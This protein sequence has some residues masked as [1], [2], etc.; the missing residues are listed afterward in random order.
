MAGPLRLISLRGLGLLVAVAV[1]LLA[2]DS[3]SVVLTRMSE[4]DDV[5][6]AGYKAAEVAKT[7]PTVR[8]VALNALATAR[9]DADTHDI[10][11]PSKG[12]AIYPDGRVTLTGTKTAPTILLHRVSFLSHFAEVSTTV[13]VEPLP[14]TS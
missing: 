3:G 13:T 8:Q 1:V 10:K 5:R 11:V 7:G 2:V 12:F 9:Q 6:T 14:Y 4:P